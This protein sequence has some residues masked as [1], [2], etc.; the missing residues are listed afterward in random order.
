MRGHRTLKDWR[1]SLDEVRRALCN[2]Q[3]RQEVGQSLRFFQ[4]F[5]RRNLHQPLLRARHL[6]TRCDK[7]DVEPASCQKDQSTK[8]RI[9]FRETS[10]PTNKMD[11]PQYG[12]DCH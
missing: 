12:K 2:I 3:S 6:E 11:C 1:L 8:Q 7:L 4:L 10:F 5:K 9:R